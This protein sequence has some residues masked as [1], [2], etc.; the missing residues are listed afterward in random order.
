LLLAA[1]QCGAAAYGVCQAKAMDNR[2]SP[3]GS[4]FNGMERCSQKE[5]MD[6]YSGEEITGAAWVLQGIQGFNRQ[7]G[8]GCLQGQLAC[9]GVMVLLLLCCARDLQNCSRL[10]GLE[11]CSKNEFMKFYSGED[12]VGTVCAIT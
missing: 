7:G 4:K 8:V 3:C 5:F 11:R 1:G 2:Q 6:F 10:N 9:K 12:C